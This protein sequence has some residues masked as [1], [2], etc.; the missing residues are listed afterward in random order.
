MLKWRQEMIRGSEA[1][2]DN[3]VI[4]SRFEENEDWLEELEDRIIELESVAHPPV[5]AGGAT[6]LKAAIEAVSERLRQVEVKLGLVKSDYE[7]DT[8]SD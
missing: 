3:P 5:E 2:E 6:E 7:Y 1:L 8:D 4:Q